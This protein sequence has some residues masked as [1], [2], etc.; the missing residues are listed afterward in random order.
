MR[1][2]QL[3]MS[4]SLLANNPDASGTCQCLEHPAKFAVNR[5]CFS[6][7]MSS[8]Q[9]MWLLRELSKV[10]K[11]QLQQN[12]GFA[13]DREFPMNLA[14][15]VWHCH[16]QLSALPPC[17]RS[18]PQRWSDETVFACTSVTSGQ[19]TANGLNHCWRWVSANVLLWIRLFNRNLI[20]T[21]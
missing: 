21:M 17:L 16:S 9:T 5:L 11:F 15:L 4:I 14:C 12:K 6:I 8:F 3:C 20:Q 13:L 7:R 18:L 10:D 2:T 1:E 19:R